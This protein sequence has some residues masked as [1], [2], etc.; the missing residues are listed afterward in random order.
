MSEESKKVEI[1]ER[2]LVELMNGIVEKAVAAEKKQ[3]LAENKAESN[4]VLEETV[5]KVDKLEKLLQGAKK[6]V[7][8]KKV[9]TEPKK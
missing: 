2:D 3:W 5:A 1:N 6:I 9:T 4:K 7:T 8:R